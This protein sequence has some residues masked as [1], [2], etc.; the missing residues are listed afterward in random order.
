M[1]GS[2]T[3][4]DRLLATIIFSQ[5]TRFTCKWQKYVQVEDSISYFHERMHHGG[6]IDM[7]I[8]KF[9]LKLWTTL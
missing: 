3:S 8:V 6:E 4:S 7:A 9:S 5:S 2:T 1:V